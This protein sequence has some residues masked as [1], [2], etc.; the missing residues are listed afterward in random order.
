MSLIS[1]VDKNKALVIVS[2]DWVGTI[3][4]KKGYKL[5]EAP[6][7]EFNSSEGLNINVLA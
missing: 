4:R 1:I 7:D 6:E 5:I 2:T 3:V